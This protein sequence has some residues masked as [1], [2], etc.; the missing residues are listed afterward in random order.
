LGLVISWIITIT[1]RLNTDDI[2]DMHE[3]VNVSQTVLLKLVDNANQLSNDYHTN[4]LVSLAA[5]ILIYF[6]IF[7][8]IFCNIIKFLIFIPSADSD[9]LR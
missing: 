5:R 1:I 9:N 7:L 3:I 8:I 4:I 6:I 2:A